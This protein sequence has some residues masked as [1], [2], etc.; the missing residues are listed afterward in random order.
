MGALRG[1]W[2][3]HAGWL[4]QHPRP[5]PR[6]QVRQ[7]PRRGPR[8]AHPQPQVPA[9]RARVA[10]DPGRPRRPA[11]LELDGRA[12]RPHLGRL[13]AHLPPAPRHLVGQL[14]L[15]LLRQAPLRRRGPLDQRLLAR[16]PVLRRELAPQPPRLPALRRARPEVVG[17]RPVRDGHRPDEARRPRLG[18]RQDHPRA[19]GAEAGRRREA[20]A[21]PRS[22][23]ERRSPSP[24][25]SWQQFA[26]RSD[27]ALRDRAGDDDHLVGAG[28]AQLADV[29]CEAVRRDRRHALGSRSTACPSSWTSTHA[30]RSRCRG[31]PISAISSAKP[32]GVLP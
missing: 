24:S 12:H 6:A 10:A 18:R 31:M 5:G 30:L 27:R 26:E 4:W 14:G 3:A 21:A 15:P 32:S 29:L 7:G 19:P 9:D 13:R 23:A 2:H 20:R 1:L 25:P 16:D 17:D 28:L 11:E 22:R 8:H